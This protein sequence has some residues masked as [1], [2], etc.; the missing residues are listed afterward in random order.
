[1]EKSISTLKSN[2]SK[3]E[4][5]TKSNIKLKTKENTELITELNELRLRK[6]KLEHELDAKALVI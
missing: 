3:N 5:K 1:M 6:K 4:S 2:T